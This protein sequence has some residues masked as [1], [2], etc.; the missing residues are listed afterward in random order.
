MAS[1]GVRQVRA[2]A[3]SGSLRREGPGEGVR[4]LIF[5]ARGPAAAFRQQIGRRRRRVAAVVAFDAVKAL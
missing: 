1:P 3:F 2:P 5:T 4:L